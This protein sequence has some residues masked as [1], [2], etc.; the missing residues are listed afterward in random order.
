[1]KILQKISLINILATLFTIVGVS[2]FGSYYVQ[3][4][5]EQSIGN[6]QDILAE[7]TILRIDEFLYRRILDIQY[8]GGIL[9][10]LK[11]LIGESVVEAE[12]VSRVSASEKFT[13]PWE[14]LSFIN[15]E[16]VVMYSTL[17]EEKGEDIKND[18]ENNKAFKS[19]LSGEIYVS[20]VV[21]SEETGEPT[22]ILATPVR[23]IEVI[24][25]PIV[26]VCIGHLVWPAVL[27]NLDIYKIE[28]AYLYNKNGEFIGSNRAEDTR[29]I[30]NPEHNLKQNDYFLGSETA[31]LVMPGIKNGE[32]SL[33][34]HIHES[35]YLD[36]LGKDWFLIVE[37]PTS[38]AFKGIIMTAIVT[39]GIAIAIILLS[40]LAVLFLLHKIIV[41]PIIGLSGVTREIVSGNLNKRASVSSGDEFGDLGTN[42]NQMA[43]SLLEAQVTL[44][45][46]VALRTKELDEKI[47]ELED[48]QKAV[49]NILEDVQHERDHVM[50]ERD[51]I[52]TI[53]KSIGDGVFVV[54][55]KMNMVLA[56]DVV[57]ELSG[58][59]LSEMIGKP[60]QKF[61]R[62]VY[63]GSAKNEVNDRFVKDALATGKTQ[64]MAN[65]TVLIHRDGSRLPVADSSAPLHNVNGKVVGC[66]V[67]FRDVTRERA[68]DKAKTEFVS[69]ASHQLRTPLSAIN[70]YS[71]MLID[72]DA[73]KLSADQ[74]KYMLEISRGNK[75]MIDLV[76]ALLNVSRLELGTFSIEPGS[77]K[78]TEVAE[79]ELKA[80]ELKIKEKK[81]KVL[82]KYAT[83]LPKKYPADAKLLSIVV[84]NILSNAVKYTPAKG[85][86]DLFIYK[87]KSNVLITV[88]DTGYGIP[89]LQ[90]SRIFEKLFRAD[91]VRAMDTDGT[92]L[93]LYI[94]KMI[95]DQ[96]G[97][98]IWFESI[99]G[100]GTKFYVEMPVKGWQKKEGT[101]KLD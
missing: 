10:P 42:F 34:S 64:E 70:W 68:I 69:L 63:E 93:G 55:A 61:L 21:I 60:Y 67:V 57:E 3:N 13:G 95:L 27:E 72:G 44:A 32:Q 46:K 5:M 43:D 94:V 62:F 76:S 52:D 71:E 2:F 33:I 49:V 26:G 50:E 58:F 29:F 97:G 9:P 73:G 23:N 77:V 88:K 22:I 19:A 20:D 4:L 8:I 45:K 92:G 85:K 91:N 31:A 37:T 15:A 74:M 47:I 38:E 53:L 28:N 14:V 18:P 17:G 11:L 79:N 83:D 30:L 87:E 24:T 35:G 66:V 101:K 56:N 96:V 7:Q 12:I 51:K 89:K 40:T 1:M 16:G 59:S 25:Q 80:L 82:K 90:Q 39:S 81:I 84:G 99:E 78:I 48:S 6:K 98:K 65:H 75:R 36:Y 86:V 41:K 100:K 54:D